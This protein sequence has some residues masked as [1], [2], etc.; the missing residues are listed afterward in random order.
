[1]KLPIEVF[2]DEIFKDYK[3]GNMK[4][5][6]GHLDK[7][8]PKSCEKTYMG[9]NHKDWVNI[10]TRKDTTLKGSIEPEIKLR[11][12]ERD[13]EWIPWIKNNKRGIK[14]YGK[15]SDFYK[16]LEKMKEIHSNKNHDYSGEGDPFRNFK[17]SE[18][19][20][21]PAWKGCLIR[22]GDKYSRLCSFAKKEEYKVKDENIEDTLMD[23]A[24]YSLIDIILYREKSKKE[25]D[26]PK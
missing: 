4:K 26:V 23:L 17:M 8:V 22:M 11:L 24:I 19:M 21:I 12:K 13:W 16:L 10:I 15:L 25:N 18:E 2:Y 14:P 9:G 20:G 6:Y 5:F 7:L 3:G 1:M